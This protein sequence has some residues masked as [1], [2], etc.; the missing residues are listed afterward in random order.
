MSE[1][2]QPSSVE[3]AL[4]ARA[5]HPDYELVAGGTDLYVA[6]KDRP[7]PPG[8]IDL[9]G[10]PGLSEVS[11]ADAGGLRIGAATT[12]ATL[13]S[14]AR[15]AQR[16]AL[17]HS[18]CRE[19]GAAQIQSRGTIGGNMVTSSPVGDSLPP[20]MALDAE[21][22]LANQQ[23]SRRLA[24][25]DFLTGYRK[26]DLKS[27]ELL[28]AIHLPAPH[29]DAVQFWRKVGTRRAQSISKVMVAAIAHLEEGK[30]AG[31]RVSVG[32]V[33]DRTIRASAAEEAMVGKA[34]NQATAEAASQAL[35]SEIQP[36]DDLRS[37]ADYRLEVAANLVARFV[38]TLSEG[39]PKVP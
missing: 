5:K 39:G 18:A 9:F 11:D 20:L 31:A 35:R 36:I 22:E 34:P 8:T 38:L 29:K 32:A 37:T 15:I 17:L 6:S 30:I 10:I 28:V 1:F 25:A 2:L 23:G 16:Y 7:S 19:V 24:Y 27:D 4:E 21:V 13:L 14:D 33:A 12:Y 26:V 3:A